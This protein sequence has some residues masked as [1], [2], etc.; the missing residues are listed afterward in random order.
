MSAPQVPPYLKFT[1]TLDALNNWVATT[2]LPMPDMDELAA[3]Y[4]R[5][6]PYFLPFWY[7]ESAH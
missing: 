7:P 3:R 1:P 5:A 2:G 6:S 4:Q